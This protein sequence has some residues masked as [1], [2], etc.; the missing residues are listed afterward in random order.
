M[1]A[2]FKFSL[3]NLSLLPI[4]MPPLKGFWLHQK[5]QEIKGLYWIILGMPCK[6]AALY[7]YPAT[8]SLSQA[9]TNW[10]RVFTLKL[11]LYFG[12]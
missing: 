4:L 3:Q 1:A 5:Q 6:K 2:I 9:C 10:V 8:C 7:T 12:M 11:A